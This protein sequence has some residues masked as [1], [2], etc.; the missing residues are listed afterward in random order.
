[1]STLSQNVKQAIHD[2][3]T[4]KDAI[5]YKGIEIPEGTHTSEYAEKIHEIE[6]GITPAGTISI[7][8]NGTGIDVAEYASAD[9]NVETYEAVLTNLIERDI[10][11]IDIPQGTTRIGEYACAHCGNLNSVTIPNSV[12][13]IADYAFYASSFSTIELPENVRFIGN[14]AFDNCSMLNN[15]NIPNG[16]ISIGDYAF[17]ACF[18]TNII[19][20]DSVTY[21]GEY[22]F[23]NTVLSDIYYTGTQAQWE[24]IT[25]GTDAIPT[26]A[27]VHYE[28]TPE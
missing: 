25:K 28:Y 17:D 23:I 16:I 7:I 5:E 9:V 15:I 14:H 27:T 3:D 4:I 18:I 2:F 19:I 1:M 20:P 11:S 12:T 10:T 8:E 26:G 22:A 13:E 21:I 6:T 24:S